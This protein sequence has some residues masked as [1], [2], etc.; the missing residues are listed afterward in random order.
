MIEPE[1]FRMQRL[2]REGVQTVASRLG[3]PVFRAAFSIEL[4]T[5]QRM[6]DRGQ[7]DAN[8]VRPAGGEAAF[9]QRGILAE[10]GNYLKVS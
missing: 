6:T 3:R 7:M 10:N 4:I 5:D 2:P 9:D 8:L 1:G